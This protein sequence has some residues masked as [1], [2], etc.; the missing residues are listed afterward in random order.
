MQVIKLK[1]EMLFILYEKGWGY[2]MSLL[3]K[4]DVK[5]FIDTILFL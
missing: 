3:E 5:F 2:E 1:M 4:N